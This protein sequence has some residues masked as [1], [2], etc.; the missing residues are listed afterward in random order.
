MLL[1]VIAVTLILG[2]IVLEL[3]LSIIIGV[4][5]GLVLASKGL[6]VHVGHL[7]IL[8]PVIRILHILEVVVVRVI[9]A[10]VLAAAVVVVVLGAYERS[11]QKWQ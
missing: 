10:A 8:V 11:A 1:L 3:R 9:L 5:G 4:L 6:A 2:L 7:T